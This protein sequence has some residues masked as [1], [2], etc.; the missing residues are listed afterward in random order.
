M[1]KNGYLLF[2]FFNIVLLV[3]GL[4]GIYIHIN[5]VIT[6]HESMLTKYMIYKDIG[7]V[8]S[9]ITAAI[10]SIIMFVVLN[11][12]SNYELE[13]IRNCCK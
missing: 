11:K 1:I 10:T 2:V 7:V 9:V 6:S 8:I 3:M 13:Q 4:V 5:A 12:Y